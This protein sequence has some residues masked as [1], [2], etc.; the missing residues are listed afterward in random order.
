M[1]EEIMTD[2]R[3]YILEVD[4]LKQHFPVAKD[5]FGRPT[6]FLRAVDGV[7]LEIYEGETFG[8]VGESG[9]GKSTLLKLICGITAKTSGK[10]SVNGSISALLELGTGFNAEYTGISNIYLNGTI[11]GKSKADITALIPE[12]K[13]FEINPMKIM[14]DG[15]TAFA[16]DMRMML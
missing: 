8:L 15:V 10:I 3:D 14:D 11:M 2:A 4:G 7:S 6:A 12:I 9:S 13:E 5:F 16:I 1:S